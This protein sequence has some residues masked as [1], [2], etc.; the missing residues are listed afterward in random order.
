ML[1]KA[2][3]ALIERD[4]VGEQAVRNIRDEGLVEETLWT[5]L[6]EELI[7]CSSDRDAVR[8]TIREVMRLDQLSGPRATYR[9][10]TLFGRATTPDDL[11]RTFKTNGYFASEAA[12]GANIR[13]YRTRGL[14]DV[15]TAWRD[16]NLGTFVMWATFDTAGRRPFEALPRT[17][18]GL[19]AVLGLPKVDRG[20]PLFLLE[21]VLPPA[22]DAYIP[23]VVEAYSGDNWV[24]YFHPTREDERDRG[25]GR[26]YI[27]DELAESGGTGVPEVVHAPVTGHALANLVDEIV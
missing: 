14:A 6:I 11:A 12:A 9:P 3:L 16:Y 18:D 8:S 21:Y 10:A 19:R 22:V 24:H 23:R 20:R 27:W 1:V 2:K 7:N 25:H 17:A 13:H 15:R 4:A 26:T 5:L